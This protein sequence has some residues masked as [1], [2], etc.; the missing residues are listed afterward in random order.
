M[1]P[2]CTW[3]ERRRD[4]IYRA[5][6]ALF[7]PVFFIQTVFSWIHS[8][9]QVIPKQMLCNRQIR[10]MQW[11]SRCAFVLFQTL[12]DHKTFHFGT[13]DSAAFDPA[14]GLVDWWG[15]RFDFR[16]CE[17]TSEVVRVSFTWHDI[18]SNLDLHS[19]RKERAALIKSFCDGISCYNQVFILNV[20]PHES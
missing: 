5:N 6:T 1:V 15:A 7:E 9:R 14:R 20:Q 17:V 13:L 18:P 8:I 4:G 3:E 2:L 16:H 10:E 12:S 11:G 19:V